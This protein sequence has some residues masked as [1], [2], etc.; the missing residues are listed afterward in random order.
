[1]KIFLD[2]EFYEN[3]RTIELISIGLV[4]EDNVGYYAETTR[5]R[6][7]CAE[8]EW[9]SRN[10]YPHLI[11]E[12]AVK[13]KTQMQDEI[14]AFVGPD[15]EFWAD[16]ASYDWVALCQLFGTMMDLPAGW[17]MF[18]NDVQQFAHLLRNPK[19]PVQTDGMHN[20]LADAKHC[21]AIYTFLTDFNENRI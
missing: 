9:L 16:Y 5:A 13:Y 18:C 4:R 2:T 10:V 12:K 11:G 3:G 14:K 20:A 15:P 19:L 17:P 21:K 1:M 6:M 8:N 7:L